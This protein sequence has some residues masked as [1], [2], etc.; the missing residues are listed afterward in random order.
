MRNWMWMLVLAGMVTGKA[1]GGEPEFKPFA[2]DWNGL[3]DSPASVAF[4]LDPP[5]GKDGFIRVSAGHLARPS[6]RRLRIWGVN[7]TGKPRQ[8]RLSAAHRDGA[9]GRGGRTCLLA[10]PALPDRRGHGATDRL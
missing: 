10:A 8:E 2:V 9:V 4:L 1:I 7:I 6:G 5:A 3:P